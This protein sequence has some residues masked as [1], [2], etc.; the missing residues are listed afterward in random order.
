MLFW[1]ASLHP[2]PHVAAC[3]SVG[4]QVASLPATSFLA[5]EQRDWLE[6]RRYNGRSVFH[7][8]T[9]AGL[10]RAVLRRESLAGDWSALAAQIA[11]ALRRAIPSPEALRA[12]Q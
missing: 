4:Q 11:D 9:L 7:F 1:L 2:A 3:V 5:S 12:R 6:G 8:W 10:M